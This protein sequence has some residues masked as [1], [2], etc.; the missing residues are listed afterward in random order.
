MYLG[1]FGSSWTKQS[2]QLDDLSFL[3]KRDEAGPISAPSTAHP[4]RPLSHKNNGTSSLSKQCAVSIPL[5]VRTTR[6][7]EH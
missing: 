3:S 7:R 6:L 5:S 4:N 1:V 2:S